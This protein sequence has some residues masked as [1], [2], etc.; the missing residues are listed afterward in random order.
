MRLHITVPGKAF[1]QSDVHPSERFT[2]IYSPDTK[3]TI[4]IQFKPEVG[5][6]YLLQGVTYELTRVTAIVKVG[7]YAHPTVTE[8]TA[9][10]ENV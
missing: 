6:R 2:P 5:D 3:I 10:A 7:G 1:D 8:Y 9:N 4:G